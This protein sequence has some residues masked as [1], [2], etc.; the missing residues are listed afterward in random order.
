R[1]A[2]Q[3]VALAPYL[4]ALAHEA[5]DTGIA[6]MRPLALLEPGDSELWPVADEYLLGPLVLVAPVLAEGA[7]SRA[8]LLPKGR[9]YPWLGG[10]GRNGA[11]LAAGGATP[12][13]PGALAGADGVR[14]F[15][16]GA[17]KLEVTRGGAKLATLIVTTAAS[18]AYQ[19]SVRY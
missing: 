1:Y 18:P 13:A 7:T 6:M 17:G 9:W 4:V 11:T 10:A 19:L 16:T 3:H 2:K 12:A 8:V 14:A 5:H 15:V